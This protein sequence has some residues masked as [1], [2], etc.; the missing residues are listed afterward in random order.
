MGGGRE[1]GEGDFFSLCFGV[2][3]GHLPFPQ[4]ILSAAFRSRPRVCSSLHTHK[5]PLHVNAAHPH[6]R[7]P[8]E[9]L[10]SMDFTPKAAELILTSNIAVDL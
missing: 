5:S 7:H 8:L 10:A 9:I 2:D 6:P 3:D 4:A 1:E